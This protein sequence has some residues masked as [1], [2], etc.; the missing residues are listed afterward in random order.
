MPPPNVPYA[1]QGGELEIE[2]RVGFVVA[3]SFEIARWDKNTKTV[4]ATGVN[5]VASQT[6]SLK[7]PVGAYAGQIV[8]WDIV[9]GK[10]L[11]GDDQYSATVTI[12]QDG[13]TIFTHPWSAKFGASSKVDI[14]GGITLV[15][16]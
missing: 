13:A 8:A 1:P 2:I 16:A 14:F 12:R 4:I 5:N 9:I 10:M 11:N 6:F 15:G 7:Q 3:A